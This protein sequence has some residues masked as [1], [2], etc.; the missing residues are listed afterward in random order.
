MKKYKNL[1]IITI[2]FLLF[3]GC[4][5]VTGYQDGTPD[6][7]LTYYCGYLPTIHSEGKQLADDRDIVIVP[8][9][10]TVKDFYEKL[11]GLEEIEILD[12]YSNSPDENTALATGFLVNGK[13]GNY[14]VVVLGDV[15]G[16]GK[17]T[18]AD[19]ALAEEYSRGEEK[20]SALPYVIASD[21][22]LSMTVDSTDVDLISYAAKSENMALGWYYEAKTIVKLNPVRYEEYSKLLEE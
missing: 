7:V 15:D 5:R 17:I 14:Y 4:S 13:D 22:D 19:S 2:I 6:Y 9:G 16:D 10:E 21:V 1:I 18:A 3:S 20:A 11:S 12:S 8:C